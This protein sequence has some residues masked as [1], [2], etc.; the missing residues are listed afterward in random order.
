MSRFVT[1]YISLDPSPR[2]VVDSGMNLSLSLSHNS[3][4]RKPT[5]GCREFMMTI[6]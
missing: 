6:L 1:S 3:L 2:E 5:L 4:I